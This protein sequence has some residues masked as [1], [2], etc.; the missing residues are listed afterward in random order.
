MGKIKELQ[1][2]SASGKTKKELETELKKEGFNSYEWSDSPGTYYPP[3]H[4][5]YDEC[6]CVINGK[7][8]FI[9]D[10]K[11]YELEPGKK[12]YLPAFTV[13]ESKNKREEKV[14]YLIGEM[15]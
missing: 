14:T 15:K 13:H 12:L 10:K 4:H 7:M 1:I 3:H 9:V 5:E 2:V 6:I 11:E 8:T